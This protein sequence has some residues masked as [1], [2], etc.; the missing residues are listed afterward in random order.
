ML[1]QI[2]RQPSMLGIAAG[3]KAA[4][5]VPTT[6]THYALFLECLSAAGVGLS[7][8][9]I[10]A[11]VGDIVVRIDG[12]EI[13]TAS[14][15]FLLDL[16]KYYGDAVGANFVAGYIPI[17]FAPQWLPSFAERSVYALGTNNIGVISVEVNITAVA[18]LSAINVY[19]EVTPELR[20]LGQHIRIRRFP[21][22]FGST[23]EQEITTL[24]KEG[25]SVAYKALHIEVPGATTV[26]SATVK[27]GGNAI[28]DQVKPGL[29]TA[30]LAKELRVVQNDYY[31]ID[32]AKNRDLTSFLP[33]AGVQDF[34]QSIVWATAAPTN[35]NIYAEQIWG[36]NIK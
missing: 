20:P 28:F 29:N 2:K 17:Y 15:Q 25:N 35:Y 9:E 4:V 24:P 12:T 27:I 3:S 10:L 21:Q 30:M 22:V 1:T 36:L 6:G 19:S 11:D 34:R 13:V 23:G 8:A 14:A 7:R 26:T 32:F 18:V 5:N 31:H 16:Q 33:M